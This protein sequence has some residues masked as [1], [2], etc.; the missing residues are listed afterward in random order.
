MRAKAI[1]TE[2]IME[3][4]DGSE[5]LVLGIDHDGG[6]FVVSSRTVGVAI[7]NFLNNATSDDIRILHGHLLYAFKQAWD[8]EVVDDGQ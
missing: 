3:D 4:A 6:G 8:E 1:Y 5:R 7:Q 2:E